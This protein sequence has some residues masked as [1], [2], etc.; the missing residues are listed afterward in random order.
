M[1]NDEQL[2][3]AYEAVRMAELGY[4]GAQEYAAEA[5][6]DLQAARAKLEALIKQHPNRIEGM[7]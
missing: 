7:Q 6:R 5:E 4:R 1:T 3:A 2:Q